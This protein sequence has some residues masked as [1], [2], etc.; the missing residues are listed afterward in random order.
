M[1]MI[2]RLGGRKKKGGL[3]PPFF[4]LLLAPVVWAVLVPP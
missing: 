4:S 1:V 2:L 3:S